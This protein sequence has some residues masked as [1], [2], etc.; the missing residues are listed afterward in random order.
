MN[1]MLK[2]MLDAEENITFYKHLRLKNSPLKLD[3]LDKDEVYLTTLGNKQLNRSLRLT[4]LHAI[5]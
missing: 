2:V 1:K 4:L 3:V 5:R